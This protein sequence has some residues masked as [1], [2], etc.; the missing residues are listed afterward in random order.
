MKGGSQEYANRRKSQGGSTTQRDVKIM[1]RPQDCGTRRKSQERLGNMMRDHEQADRRVCQQ[2][3]AK[4][5]LD[6]ADNESSDETCG[7]MPDRRKTKEQTDHSV[8]TDQRTEQATELY[9]Q[10]EERRTAPALIADHEHH[11][12]M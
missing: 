8:I 2:G 3:R 12:G 1:N 6:N 5:Q 7:S 4:E 9:R 11:R 10:T